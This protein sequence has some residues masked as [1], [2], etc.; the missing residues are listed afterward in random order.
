MLGILILHAVEQ[1]RAFESRLV[2]GRNF[3]VLISQV[4][5]RLPNS[6]AFLLS[7]LREFPDYLGGT[8][9]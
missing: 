2:A 1:Y 4:E 6:T 5:Q 9:T 3:F 8:H 7:K